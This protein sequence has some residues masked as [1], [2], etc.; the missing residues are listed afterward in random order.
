MQSR[1]AARGTTDYPKTLEHIPSPPAHI[2]WLGQRLP[3][4][5]KRPS[6]AIVGTRDISIYGKRV[7]LQLARQLAEQ[8]VVIISGLAMG[9]DTLAHQATLEAGG[10]AIAVLPCPLDNILPARNHRLAQKI[11]DGGGTLITEYPSGTK[12]QK[13]YFIARN[14]IMSGLAK[15]VL[16]T[17]AGEKSGALHTAKFAIDQGK[18]VLAVPGDINHPG[19]VGSNNL[20]KSGAA[21]VSTYKDVLSA[22]GLTDHHTPVRKVYG[23]NSHEQTLLDLLLNGTTSGEQLLQMSGLKI[24]EFS[25]VLTMLEISGKIRP[26]GANNWALF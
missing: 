24:S 9:A 16:V 1:A 13:Q 3:D 2:F 4:L 18:D 19:Y 21:L 26:L 11:I 20:I 22:L 6:V 12:P 14:R 25:Q 10:L 15:A 5:L 7:T 23:R 17:E 8:G